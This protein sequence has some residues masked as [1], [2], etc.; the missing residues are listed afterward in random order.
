MRRRK[1][2]KRRMN[3]GDGS[4]ES[5]SAKT[6]PKSEKHAAEGSNEEGWRAQ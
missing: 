3:A 6:G 1:Q 2:A 4:A 5:K